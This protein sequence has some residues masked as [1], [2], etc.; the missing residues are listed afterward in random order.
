MKLG[1]K[2][3]GEGGKGLRDSKNNGGTPLLKWGRLGLFKC[4]MGLFLSRNL[5]NYKFYF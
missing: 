3:R 2:G 4:W 5:G 1:I